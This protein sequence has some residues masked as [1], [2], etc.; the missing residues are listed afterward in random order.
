[1]ARLLR[2]TAPAGSVPPVADRLMDTLTDALAA[3]RLQIEWGA[4]EALDAEPFDRF[5]LPPSHAAIVPSATPATAAPVASPLAVAVRGTPGERAA[6]TAGAAATL[7]ELRAA[8][9]SFDGSALRDT[10]TNLVFLEGDPACGLLFVGEP[11]NADADRSGTV[12]AGHVGAYMEQMLRSIG[13]DRPAFCLTPLIPWRPPGDRPPSAAEIAACLPFLHRMIT[14]IAPQR[15]VAL[16]VLPARA[17][18]GAAP[19]RRR[20][21]PSWQD[22]AIPGCALPIPTL[23]MPSPAILLSTPAQRRG[24]W[25]ALRRLRHNLDTSLTQK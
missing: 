18:L 12:L 23:P 21:S 7:E 24:A 20:A 8:M 16:G 25:A 5:R 13:L 1:M 10:A 15:I 22:A 19:M 14:L 9:A 2:K 17:L 4:D 11:P 3:L 6:R